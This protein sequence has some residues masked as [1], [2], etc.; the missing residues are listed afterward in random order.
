MV[1]ETREFKRR[2]KTHLAPI[3]DSQNQIATTNVGIQS[4]IHK[5][6]MLQGNTDLH[7]YILKNR[8][9][10][11]VL[12]G[13]PYY[14]KLFLKAKESPVTI[15]FAYKKYEDLCVY[16]SQ[17]VL[18]PSREAYH[19]KKRKP[20]RMIIKTKKT[21]DEMLYFTFESESGTNISLNI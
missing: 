3:G 14:A 2:K 15:N 18:L 1:S 5:L 20:L 7:A 12:P 8:H 16:A 11:F 6:N 10:A 21:L 9:T 19:I 4:A 13:V 17:S